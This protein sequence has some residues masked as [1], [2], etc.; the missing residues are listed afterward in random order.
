MSVLEDAKNINFEKL[1]LQ[2]VQKLY[3]RGICVFYASAK[4]VG[5]EHEETIYNI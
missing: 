3:K 4:P 2:D 5:F 1:T